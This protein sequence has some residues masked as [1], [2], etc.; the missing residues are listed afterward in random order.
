MRTRGAWSAPPSGA[1]AKLSAARVATVLVYLE[2][3][4]AGGETIF[5]CVRPWDRN[6]LDAPTGF[7]TIAQRLA[8][9]I[10]RKLGAHGCVACLARRAPPQCAAAQAATQAET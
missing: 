7:E 10:W 6:S 1:S 5:P 9:F 8:A 2:R 3:A 4:L